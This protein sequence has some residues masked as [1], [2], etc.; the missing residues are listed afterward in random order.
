MDGGGMW[1]LEVVGGGDGIVVGGLILCGSGSINIKLTQVKL[2]LQLLPP[3]ATNIFQP[4][5]A[6]TIHH[7]QLS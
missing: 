1:W 3:T 4:P 5:H 2:R 6:T 7:H